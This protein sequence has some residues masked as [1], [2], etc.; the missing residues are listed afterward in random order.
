MA[1]RASAT[2]YVL[3][4]AWRTEEALSGRDGRASIGEL[5]IGLERAAAE[6]LTASHAH[7]PSFRAVF[8]SPQR[9][10]RALEPFF[11]ATIR[12]AQRFGVV[13]AA[14][15]GERVL[16]VSVWLP[17]GAFPWSSARKLRATPEL[18]RVLAADPRRFRSFMRYGT[19]AERL[20]PSDRHWYLVVA[21]VRPEAQGRLIGTRLMHDEL[22]ATDTA[23][24][25]VYL[26]TADRGNIDFYERFGFTVTDGALELV[27]GGPTHVAMRRPAVT[28]PEVLEAL[29]AA[30]MAPRSAES[31]RSD[32]SA[33]SAGSSG[34]QNVQNR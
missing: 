14:W 5:P 12:D 25:P 31:L 16:G 28:H 13:R 21:G 20:H 2:E 1:V 34:S 22:Q 3:M 8:P 17:P 26:E 33:A 4:A 15:E 10:A 9:R 27:P 23:G 24:L 32:G 19:N 30:L 11:H 7:Y 6:A 29:R 18:L